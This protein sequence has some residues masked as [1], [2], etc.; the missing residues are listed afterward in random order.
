MSPPA[1][2]MH[3]GSPTPQTRHSHGSRA[4]ELLHPC[5]L[6]L[7]K[8]CARVC[9]SLVHWTSHS[10]AFRPTLGMWEAAR[11]SVTQCSDSTL[12]SQLLNAGS[13]TQQWLFQGVRHF[14]ELQQA[15]TACTQYSTM[16]HDYIKAAG[17]K[18]WH[19]INNM[20]SPQR[21]QNTACK[22][23]ILTRN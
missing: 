20:R 21:S 17:M 13:S 5:S 11:P 16:L 19:L 9:L 12:A 10:L 23:V 7:G 15:K 8:M 4:E 14:K 22:N 1:V 18:N 6:L 2:L 3:L